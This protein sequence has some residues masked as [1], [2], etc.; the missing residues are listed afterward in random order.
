MLNI[1]NWCLIDWAEPHTGHRC[2]R[3]VFRATPL[4]TERCGCG[5][6][7]PDIGGGL[8]NL[9]NSCHNGGADRPADPLRWR[10]SQ[11]MYWSTGSVHRGLAE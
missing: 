9:L 2:S 3:N 10:P 5:T 4:G 1:G 7:V 8:D 6:T 11:C